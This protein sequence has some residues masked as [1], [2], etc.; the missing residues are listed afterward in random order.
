MVCSGYP[1]ESMLISGLL[2]Q[3]AGLRDNQRSTPMQ[4][5]TLALKL[6]PLV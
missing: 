2:L 4:A 6:F 5:F 1:V 3:P